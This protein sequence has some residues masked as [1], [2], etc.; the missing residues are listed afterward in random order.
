MGDCIGYSIA[1]MGVEV[2]MGNET[3]GSANES[4]KPMHSMFVITVFLS[5]MALP[6]YCATRSAMTPEE[7]YIGRFQPWRTGRA[8][9]VCPSASI[10]WRQGMRAVKQNHTRPIWAEI[11]AS[12]LRANFNI[13]QETAGE[14]VEILAVIKADAYGHGATEC[15]P[16]LAAAG[17]RWLGVT[18]VDEGVAVRS[19][20]GILPQGLAP[21]ILVMCSLWPGEE[22]ACLDRSLTPVVWE[23]YHLDLMEAEAIRRGL[24]PRS[25]PVHVEVDTG[26]ARQGVPPGPFLQSLLSR[27]TPA[28]PLLLE[29]VMTHLAST[30][31][32]ADPQ[33]QRQMAAFTDALAQVAAFG[34]APKIVHAGNTSSTDSGFV[35][36]DLPALAARYGAAAMTRTG[37]GLYG[38]ALPLSGAESLARPAL[39]PAMAWKTRVVSIREV[40]TGDTIGYN[41]TFVAP[42]LMRLA[43]LPV[44]YA[45]GFRRSLSASNDK[46]GGAVLLHGMRAPIVGRVSMDLTIVDITAIPGVSIGDEAVLLGAQ[47]GRYGDDAIPAEEHATLASTSVYEIL[48][49]ISDRVPR[50]VT[51]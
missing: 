21:R 14:S 49:G 26:M 16:V 11:S 15:A 32:V 37:L 38:Y 9:S 41:G 24:Q 35:P 33:N 2:K 17:A 1:P 10:A 30:E 19:S 13:L 22:A 44:G 20:L 34:L 5:M 7:E 45:D 40:Q 28:S 18:S 3:L 12:R 31:T 50:M 36:H 46:A 8:T 23:P 39:R 4:E 43:L 29:G 6:C 51:N 42:G 27:F 47:T 48:C 25:V